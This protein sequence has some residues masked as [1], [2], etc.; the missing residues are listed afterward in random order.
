MKA[1]SPSPLNLFG[2]STIETDLVPQ[3]NLISSRQ[4][5]LSEGIS[6]AIV[7][8]SKYLKRLLSDKRTYYAAT[9]IAAVA[10]I[11]ACALCRDSSKSAKFNT[12]KIG[13]MKI[14]Y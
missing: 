14:Y 12:S 2:P 9:A 5:N 11:A 6:N 8:G 13:N 7:S 3:K 4:K 10:G 1:R